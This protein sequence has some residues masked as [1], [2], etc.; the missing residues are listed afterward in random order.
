MSCCNIETRVTKNRSDDEINVSPYF[1]ENRKVDPAALDHA[2]LNQNI[3]FCGHLIFQGFAHADLM[4]EDMQNLRPIRVD[5]AST[6][7]DFLS[8]SQLFL[9]LR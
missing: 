2:V 1:R 3:N 6:P 9:A 5:E 8:R 7:L 4:E